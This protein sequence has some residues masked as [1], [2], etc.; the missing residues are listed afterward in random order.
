MMVKRGNSF[1]IPHG[2]TYFQMGD[3]LH[4]FGTNSALEDTR[5]KVG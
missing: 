3:I 2:D 4:V 5:Q 1:Y